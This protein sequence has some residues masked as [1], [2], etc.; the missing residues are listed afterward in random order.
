MLPTF[1]RVVSVAEPKRER[2]RAAAEP[3]LSRACSAASPT[4]SRAW[5][6]RSRAWSTRSRASPSRSEPERSSAS[7]ICESPLRAR[8]TAETA[9]HPAP[10]VTIATGMGLS[11]T[12]CGSRSLPRDADS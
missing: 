10:T 8:C 1:C 5:S 3:T 12:I 7:S 2:A 4:R 6:T 11:R 9:S